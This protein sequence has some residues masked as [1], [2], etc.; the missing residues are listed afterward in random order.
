MAQVRRFD[1][2]A[3]VGRAGRARPVKPPVQQ[4][5]HGAGTARVFVCWSGPRSERLAELCRTFLEDLVPPL[6]GRIFT[7]PQI[8]KGARWFE[9]VL[10]QLETAHVGIICMTREA[11]DAPWLHFEAGALLRGMHLHPRR[12]RRSPS[13]P[14]RNRVFTLL[15]GVSAAQLGGPLS[16][17]QSTAT[18]FSDIFSLVRAICRALHIDQATLTPEKFSEAWPA[19]ERQLQQLHQPVHKLLPS[20]ESWFERKTFEESIDRCTDQNWLGRYDGAREVSDR[21][22]RNLDAVVAACPQYQVDLY[23]QL[24]ML[25]DTYGMATRSLLVRSKPFDLLESGR[26]G[27]PRGIVAACEERRQRIKEILSRILDPIAVPLSEAAACFWLSDSYD[28][29]KMIIHRSE[30]DVR[31]ALDSPA[32]AVVLPNLER[33]RELTDSLW[34][35]DRIHGYLLAEIVYASERDTVDEL[36]RATTAEIGR[37]RITSRSLLPLE[38]GLRALR[39]GLTNER[40]RRSAVRRRQITKLWNDL[41]DVLRARTAAVDAETADRDGVNRIRR[42]VRDMEEIL[43]MRSDATTAWA[44]GRV[45]RRRLSGGQRSRR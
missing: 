38:Y 33:S 36:V 42:V 16:Q 11:L 1:S 15:H 25:L 27:I 17:Y 35:L 43:A 13:E 14:V 32:A 23:K 20:F 41:R 28:Q 40:R 3:T 12:R 44:D 6:Q 7:S 22:E 34:E 31:A 18:T 19:L 9:E 26:L 29:K 2:R 21:L 10:R 39:A 8:E 45:R 37:C 4:S 24:M 5:A 30:H